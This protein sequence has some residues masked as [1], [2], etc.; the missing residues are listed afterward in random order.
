M[1]KRTSKL[2]GSVID[3]LRLE[4]DFKHNINQYFHYDSACWRAI[5]EHIGKNKECA[6]FI[7]PVDEDKATLDVMVGRGTGYII[8]MRNVYIHYT[9][10][11]T[12]AIE[13]VVWYFGGKWTRGN[14][15]EIKRKY[16]IEVPFDL[17]E[18]FTK[19]K[20]DAWIKEELAKRQ[21][22]QAK[23]DLPLLSELIKKYPRE[24]KEML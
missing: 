24:A 20:F 4:R 10:G 3:A 6:F 9:E 19:E 7:K 2:V 11:D 13:L 16:T 23:D 1:I 21:S 8:N 18:N 12:F 15:R 17:E 5:V 22:E 14:P